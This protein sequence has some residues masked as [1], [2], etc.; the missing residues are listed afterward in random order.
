MIATVHPFRSSLFDPEA[1]HAMGEAYDLACQTLPDI[2][3]HEIIARAILRASQNGERRPD[4]LY[5]IALDT[6]NSVLSPGK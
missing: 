6:L 1:L 5:E 3:D 4:A 2:R